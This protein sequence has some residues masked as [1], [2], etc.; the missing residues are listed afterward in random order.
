[1]NRIDRLQSYPKYNFYSD[2]YYS[3]NE[4]IKGIIHKKE[5][6]VFTVTAVNSI[7]SSDISD[8][9]VDILPI[10]SP[11]SPTLTIAKPGNQNCNISFKLPT[12]DG[13][14]SI[15]SVKV[16]ASPTNGSSPIVL[17]FQ[18][19]SLAQISGEYTLLMTGLTNNTTYSFSLIVINSSGLSSPSSNSLT[20]TP[21]IIQNAPTITSIV[22]DNGKC[23]VSFKP[24]FL[25]DYSTIFQYI[26]T[27]KPDSGNSIETILKVSSLN[28]SGT[29]PNATY[30]TTFS[31]LTNGV[32]YS[33]SIIAENLTGKSQPS[34]IVKSIPGTVPDSPAIQKVIAGDSNCS[35]TFKEPLN[36]GGYMIDSYIINIKGN[37]NSTSS[38]TFKM[39]DLKLLS[40]EYTVTIPSLKN[41]VIYTFTIAATN[42]MGTGSYSVSSSEVKPN[43]KPF[44]P[45][46]V[47]A[48][49]NENQQSTVSFSGQNENGSTITSYTVT[50]SPGGITQSGTSSPIIIKGLTNGTS[51]TFTVTVTNSNGTSVSGNSNSI[52]P[53]S[54]PS[55]ITWNNPAGTSL[56][57]S[58]QLKFKTPN[59]NGSNITS[60]KFN[61]YYTDDLNKIY[62]ETIEV[63]ISNVV[64]NNDGTSTVTLYTK[65]LKKYNKLPISASD[66]YSTDATLK[67]TQ[68]STKTLSITSIQPY[69]KVNLKNYPIGKERNSM[70]LY[71]CCY[72]IGIILFIALFIIIIYKYLNKKH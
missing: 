25:G 47:T 10:I 64:N 1:M 28:L 3:N 23:K 66:L 71:D 56:N 53:S 38:V 58:I 4:L 40:G 9:T 49:S 22:P 24:D 15:N 63:P 34:T 41:G 42:S 7:G 55:P 32:S 45:T 59:N 19:S 48:T 5:P 12:S 57:N 29:I 16:T 27:T 51:Y 2:D 36:N 17:P 13:G 30:N 46:L 61:A 35:L 8:P 44:P 60:Y 21:G 68:S 72:N 52:I 14:S 69:D 39:S 62:Y 26:I 31:G 65:E 37:D 20:A 54:K 18:L 50:S 67:P 33:F 70:F 43:G 6:Y 11:S